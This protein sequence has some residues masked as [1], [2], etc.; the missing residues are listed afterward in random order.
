MGYL[1]TL[2]KNLSEQ[3]GDARPA[4]AVLLKALA[5][6]SR[7]TAMNVFCATPLTLSMATQLPPSRAPL[8]TWRHWRRT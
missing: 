6:S 4:L 2:A 7:H 3:G 5:D 1:A 8:C